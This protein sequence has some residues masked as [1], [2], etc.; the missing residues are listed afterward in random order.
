MI[1]SQKDSAL[2]SIFFV[3]LFFNTWSHHP[4]QAR[5]FH[6]GHV[7]DAWFLDRTGLLAAGWTNILASWNCLLARFCP[8]GRLLSVS[9]LD[10]SI[11][12]WFFRMSSCMELYQCQNSVFEFGMQTCNPECRMSIHESRNVISW[13]EN[14]IRECRIHSGMQPVSWESQSIMRFVNSSSQTCKAESQ[15][16]I[17]NV[18]ALLGLSVW[19]EL[20]ITWARPIFYYAFSHPDISPQLSYNRK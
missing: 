9:A 20:L 5:A 8:L 1:I 15:N 11:D 3:F 18:N 2:F 13:R 17:R 12:W 7:Y 16:R 14:S 4:L 6:E 19:R 10:T